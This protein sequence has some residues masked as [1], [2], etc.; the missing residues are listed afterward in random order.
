MERVTAGVVGIAPV[1]AGAASFSVTPSVA[2]FASA[3]T[4]ELRTLAE[5]LLE[6][7]TSGEHAAVPCSAGRP[8]ANSAWLPSHA[9]GMS[10]G[11]LTLLGA[12]AASQPAMRRLAFLAEVRARLNAW[13]RGTPDTGHVLS[14]LADA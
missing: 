13:P 11:E 7:E 3:I 10:G 8:R 14:G 4:V 12:M 9:P 5:D 6:V 2:A 1:G